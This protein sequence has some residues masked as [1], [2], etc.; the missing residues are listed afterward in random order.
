MLVQETMNFDQFSLLNTNDEFNNTL[1]NYSQPIL[2]SKSMKRLQNFIPSTKPLQN[3]RYKNKMKAP[4][5]KFVKTVPN[6]EGRAIKKTSSLEN[7]YF[8]TRKT[9]SKERDTLNCSIRISSLI[10]K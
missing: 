10:Q 2:A 5:T 8:P 3:L 6:V 7:N 9:E 4:L 1:K